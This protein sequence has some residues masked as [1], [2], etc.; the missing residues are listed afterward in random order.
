MN[1]NISGE[2]QQY[3]TQKLVNALNSQ[4]IGKIENIV[5]KNIL[6]SAN[7]VNKSNENILHVLSKNYYNLNGGFKTMQC[8]LNVCDDNSINKQDCNGNTPLIN[9]VKCG[10][11]ELCELFIQH[12][13]NRFIKNKEGFYVEQLNEEDDDE[14]DF[15]LN[16]EGLYTEDYQIPEN[17]HEL[18]NKSVVKK[19]QTRHKNKYLQSEYDNSTINT[20]N[21]NKSASQSESS[22]YFDDLISQIKLNNNKKHYTENALT[23]T[24]SD[25]NQN[26]N[27]NQDGGNIIR[28]KRTIKKNVDKHDAV[29]SMENN[30]VET[31]FKKYAREL[32]RLID[33]QKTQIYERIVKKIMNLLNVTDDIARF[34]KTSLIKM[35]QKK[36]KDLTGLDLAN[37]VEKL[38]TT[39]VLQKINIE[40]EKNKILKWR[41]EHNSSESEKSKRKNSESTSSDSSEEHK[42]LKKQKKIKNK[43]SESS[44]SSIS[45][46]KISLDDFSSTSE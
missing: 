4:N 18:I 30:N 9:A 14:F 36:N 12:G 34:Y 45:M 19:L 46:S 29:L 5:N 35:A 13:A 25:D 28:G 24:E 27:N 38:A 20:L 21:Y 3:Y 37:E 43:L 8:A 32:G 33:K 31:S 1:N 7:V 40:E 16:S 42:K 44:M 17:P 22:K 39:S 41:E 26:S 6:N 23:D 15:S 10:A 2:K 11:S